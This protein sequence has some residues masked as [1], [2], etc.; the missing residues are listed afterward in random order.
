MNGLARSFYG[1]PELAPLAPAESPIVETEDTLATRRAR[2]LMSAEWNFQ[3]YVWSDNEFPPLLCE[4]RDLQELLGPHTI[5][6]TFYDRDYNVVTCAEKPGRYGAVI[7]ITPENGR[8]MRR[9]RTLFRQ[10]QNF[11]WWRTYVPIPFTLPPEIGIDAGVAK[12]QERT[13]GNY[14]KEQ[15]MR[16]LQRDPGSAAIFAGLYE[17]VADEG[18]HSSHNDAW[19]RDRQWWVGLKRKLDGTDQEFSQ[20]VHAPRK[21]DGLDTPVLREGSVDE[22]GMKPEVVKKLDE[23]LRAWAADSDQAFAVC[24]ARRGVV[25]FERAYGMRDGQPMTMETGSYMASITKLMAGSLVMMLVDEGRVALDEPINKYLPALRG[26]AVQAPLTLRHLMRHTN[27]L[28]H[29]LGDEMN[30]FEHIVADIYAHLEIGRRYEYN[31]AGYALAGKVIE[32]VSGEALA[33]FFHRH[34]LEPLG[35]QHTDVSTMSWNAW[36]TS[37]DIATFAQML[38]NRGAYGNMRFFSPSTF[39]QMLP[40][41]LSDVLGAEATGEYG[42]GSSWFKDEGLGMGTFGHGAASSATLRIDPTN[43]L[44]VTMSRNEAGSNFD[45]YHPQ[46]LRLVGEGVS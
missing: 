15:F 13:L 31:G 28:W 22:A 2:L 30:D 25:F 39:E 24:L 29:H 12:V 6:T 46:F 9:C 44:I 40:Q 45:Q 37:R 19:A 38:L 36:S 11:V 7:D 43:E 14:F 8:A 17:S 16:S 35:M 42:I 41:S 34:L 18:P 33:I 5:T 20:P 3:P 32:A 23:L 26:I 4:N 21:E 1:L 27:G 10:P